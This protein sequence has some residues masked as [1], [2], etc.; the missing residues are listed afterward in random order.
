MADPAQVDPT[1]WTGLIRRVGRLLHG[2]GLAGPFMGLPLRPPRE[3]ALR[4][5]GAG[6]AIRG[7][8]LGSTTVGRGGPGSG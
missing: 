1:M 5:I 7:P 2:T 8:P 4:E 6:A 3:S